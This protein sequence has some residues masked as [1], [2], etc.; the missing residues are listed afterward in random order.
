MP[1]VFAALTLTALAA[2]AQPA[3]RAPSKLFP[4]LTHLELK[5]EGV[6]V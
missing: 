3:P 2:A 5:Q 6:H 4:E 1:A